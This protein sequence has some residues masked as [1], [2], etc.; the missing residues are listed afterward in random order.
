[1]DEVDHPAR[2]AQLRHR[3]HR[4]LQPGRRPVR[5]AREGQAP[6]PQRPPQGQPGRLRGLVLPG[7]G[8]RR[9]RR[10]RPGP[11]DPRRRRLRRARTRSRSR[12][13]AASPSPAWKRGKSESPGASPT[14]EPADTSTDPIP[15][16]IPDS[17][18]TDTVACQVCYFT[19]PDEAPRGLSHRAQ[20]ETELATDEHRW[21][22]EE[23]QRSDRFVIPRSGKGGSEP[24]PRPHVPCDFLSV[25]ICVHLWLILYSS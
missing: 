8:R 21:Q 20:Q 2:P 12:A 14:C 24:G 3:Q 11:R 13:S 9:E 23:S 4:L 10:L 5:R 22:D 1:M 19:W 25:F 17:G 6:G 7:R 16:P 15:F 18:H